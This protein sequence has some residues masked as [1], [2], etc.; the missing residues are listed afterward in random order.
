MFPVL[1]SDSYDCSPIKLEYINPNK[2]FIGDFIRTESKE[3]YKFQEELSSVYDFAINKDSVNILTD[4]RGNFSIG[5]P[6]SKLAIYGDTPS[7]ECD[8][9]IDASWN[10]WLS[11]GVSEPKINRIDTPFWDDTTFWKDREIWSDDSSGGSNYISKCNIIP[12]KNNFTEVNT[13]FCNDIRTYRNLDMG[14]RGLDKFKPNLIY[15]INTKTDIYTEDEFIFRLPNFSDDIPID[16]LDF[17]CFGSVA[18]ENIEFADRILWGDNRVTWLSGGMCDNIWVDRVYGLSGSSLN[19]SLDSVSFVDNH[20]SELILMSEV[21]YNYVRP[22]SRVVEDV[23][24]DNL[25]FGLNNV[26]DAEVIDI[27][28]NNNNGEF[29]LNE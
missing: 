4:V 16:S 11:F 26:S 12:L 27:S 28:S 14:E 1:S 18:N 17:S 21:D 2:D 8:I 6:Q 24:S 10:Y 22:T 29:I 15:D 7:L 5:L 9:D 23:V 13:P 19:T 20:P 25:I 3:C